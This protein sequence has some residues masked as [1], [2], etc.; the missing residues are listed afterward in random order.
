MDR[1][2]TGRTDGTPRMQKALIVL[3]RYIDIRVMYGVMAVVIVGYML[4]RPSATRAQYTYFRRC[5]SLGLIQALIR[6]YCNFF[7]FGQ[8]VLDR[9][10]AY[11]GRTFRFIYEDEP[12]FREMLDSGAGGLLLSSHA[13]NFEMAGYTFSPGNRTMWALAY[14]GESEVVR[15]KREQMLNRNHI[16]VISVKDDMSHVF[17]LHDALSHGDIVSMPGDRQL[18]HSRDIK[19]LFFGQAA[20]F[21]MGP[22]HIASRMRVCTL[23]MWV[24]KEKWDTYRVL[25]RRV[26]GTTAQ[27][28]ADSYAAQLEQVV[29]HYPTQWY[30]YYDFWNGQIDRTQPFDR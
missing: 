26:E 19:S 22:F 2:W 4:F 30:H 12:L 7:R 17:L 28:L 11:A 3:F 13:G 23:A 14:A 9:F 16:H 6:T 29:R 24:M 20:P 18:G 8:V 21:P 27:Q 15:R 1:Q 25:V 10:A 5:Y